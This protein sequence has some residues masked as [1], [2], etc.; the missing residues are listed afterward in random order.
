MHDFKAAAL[1]SEGELDTRAGEHPYSASTTF[2]FNT[3]KEFAPWEQQWQFVT[4][5]NVKD[6]DVVL[7]EGF[8]GN[9]AGGRARCAQ[10]QFLLGAKGGPAEGVLGCPAET[11]VGVVQ[12]FT[13]GAARSPVVTPVYNLNPPAGVPAEFGFTFDNTPVRLDA[14]VR[15]IDGVYRVTVL[16]PD[17]NAY[18]NIYGISLTLWG[19]PADSSHDPE[20]R[21]SEEHKQSGAESKETPHRP[22][23]T[24]PVDCLKQA[25]EHPV[26]VLRYDQWESPGASNSEGEPLL[27]GGEPGWHELSSQPLP[28]VTGCGELSFNPHVAFG[29]LPPAQGGSS[30]AS[31]PSGYR[32][33]LELPQ[34]E[35]VGT[36]ATPQLKDTTVTLA[37]GVT[38]S[39]SAANGLQ[40]CSASQID[41]ADTTPGAVPRSRPGRRG[42]HQERAAR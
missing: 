36:L 41:L 9:P 5:G 25:Q 20:R 26:T 1:N 32:F 23:L 38:L 37:P 2:F 27:S 16:S 12:V 21:F 28:P 30:R 31:A 14:H 3:V 18:L 10:P 8:L 40:A 22:F 35:E 34:S 13:A 24:N 4:S 11:Q 6:T 15:R 42:P 7:P 29:P 19:V 33:A 39:P 17:I